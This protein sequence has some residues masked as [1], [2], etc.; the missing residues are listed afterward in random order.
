MID[1]N[2][3]RITRRPMV[4]AALCLVVALI[5]TVAWAQGTGTEGATTTAAPVRSGL[6]IDALS[7]ELP[8]IYALFMTSW[9]INGVIALLSILALLLFLYFFATINTASMA[10]TVFVDEVSKLVISRKFEEL[11]SLCRANPRV[12]IATIVQRCAEN[13]GKEHS[14]IMDMIDS[15]GRRR[16]DLIWNRV[17][18]L[19]DVSN[20]APMLGLLGTVIGMIK[21]FF[22]LP[23]G[24]GNL[25]SGVLSLG[26][27][28]AMATTMFGLIVAII[29]LAFYS[30]IKARATRALAAAEQVVHSIADH[31]KRGGA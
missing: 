24:S 23:T 11:A 8:T 26:V 6:G 19:A 16:A 27:A 1:R 9:L 3:S 20:V 18:Y 5:G 17:S 7:G 13:A 29:S 30:F 28:E 25:N 10:P 2:A 14:V 22:T 21:A 12:F 15:E 31:I 4:A